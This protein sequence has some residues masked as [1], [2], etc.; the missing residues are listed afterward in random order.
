[1]IMN[2]NNLK[3]YGKAENFIVNLDSLKCQDLCNVTKYIRYYLYM[4]RDI[5]SINRRTRCGI[6]NASQLV[7]VYEFIQTN[8]NNNTV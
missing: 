7:R 8:L 2:N 1:M 6:Q 4:G 3:W 5:N